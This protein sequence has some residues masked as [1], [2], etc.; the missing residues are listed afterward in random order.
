MNRDCLSIEELERVRALAADDPRRL[1]AE[2]C[3]RCASLL[4]GLQLFND[5]S[6]PAA[7]AKLEDAERHLA[8][9]LDPRRLPAHRHRRRPRRQWF[10]LA[11]A[12]AVVLLALGVPRH[13]AVAP[14]PPV[15]RGEGQMPASLPHGTALWKEDGALTLSWP[16]FSG[17]DHVEVVFLAL[18]LHE[19]AR[20]S[21]NEGNQLVLN[22]I[23]LPSLLKEGEAVLW[24]AVSMKDGE[25]IAHTARQLLKP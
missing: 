6:E 24:S 16:P 15:L 12:A 5:P 3:P 21:A 7:G 9:I 11:G 25:E 1:H 23:D 13:T 10:L 19:V 2:T 4:A 8:E 20:I 18:D 17:G 14:S 22:R